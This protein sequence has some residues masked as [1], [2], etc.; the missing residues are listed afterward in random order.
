M[1]GGRGT[2]LGAVGADTEKPLVEVGGEP[3]IDR[4][5]AALSAG[6]VDR[7][8]A[9][10]SPNAPETAASL[11]DRESDARVGGDGDC[12]DDSDDGDDAATAGVSVVDAPGDGYVADLGY[13]LERVERPV[14]T[15]AADLP[16]LSAGV[17]DRAIDAAGDA[18][19]SVYVPVE[20]K[21][22]LGVSVDEETT[23]RRDGREVAPTGLNVVGVDDGEYGDENAL[24]VAD[25]GLAVNVNR[26]RDLRVA[27]AL[28]RRRARDEASA[29]DHGDH[30]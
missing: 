11:R 29:A 16:L 15:V 5:L 30:P 23:T 9:V 13:A 28:L 1:C 12:D 3:M 7:I 8:H 18:S 6:R 2:R 27:E 4:V 10:V 19:L 24:V 26:P 21:R 20:A 14:L 25:E 22:D 17:V